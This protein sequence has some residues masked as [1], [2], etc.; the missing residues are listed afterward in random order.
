MQVHGLDGAFW[1]DGPV[2]EGATV[3]GRPLQR[4]GGTDQRP[5]MRVEGI[6]DRGAAAALAGQ[7]VVVHE[8]LADDEWLVSDLVGAE[9]VGLGTVT[10][11]I[12]APSCDVLEVGDHLIPFIR[13]AIRS[14]DGATIE[15]DREF[16][17][18]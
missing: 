13:D 8:E 9:V 2:P 18:L 4:V 1:V 14:I 17:G 12:A 10:R 5:L 15:V 7:P 16:L 3:A 6:E 11:V